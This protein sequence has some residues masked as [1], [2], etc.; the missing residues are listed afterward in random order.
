METAR[1]L[2]NSFSECP[3]SIKARRT[4]VADRFVYQP[5]KDPPHLKK[6]SE[7]EDLKKKIIH[8]SD[9]HTKK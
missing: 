4:S 9:V 8:R 5:L 1:S 6:K 2:G 3:L 7:Q